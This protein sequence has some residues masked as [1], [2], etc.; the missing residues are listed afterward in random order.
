MKNPLFSIERLGVDVNLATMSHMYKAGGEW[1]L[2]TESGSKYAITEEEH[3]N[4]KAAFE[5]KEEHGIDLEK[6]AEM[7]KRLADLGIGN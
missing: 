2:V 7:K 4:I 3:N 6:Y 1:T 5:H